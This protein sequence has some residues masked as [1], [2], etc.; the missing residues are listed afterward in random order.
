[1]SLALEYFLLVFYLKIKVEDEINLEI[2][3]KVK[4]RGQ[5]YILLIGRNISLS[6]EKKN[7]LLL[8]F[9]GTFLY[10]V[11]QCKCV[12]KCEYHNMYKF[13]S[14]GCHDDPEA[15]RAS[16]DDMMW[17]G[18]SFV[19]RELPEVIMDT[20]TTRSTFPVLL[21]T[22]GSV[23]NTLIG[24]ICDMGIYTYYNLS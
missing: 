17:E 14:N 13:V 5:L 3:V 23:G 16:T 6:F 1:M 19:N 22:W 24:K 8:F 2:Q 15:F 7:P 12:D 11:P 21:G 4:Y 10:A 20:E 18:P 9:L